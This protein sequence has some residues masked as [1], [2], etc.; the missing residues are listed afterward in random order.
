MTQFFR[1]GDCIISLH[2]C[3]KYKKTDNTTIIGERNE[4]HA[5]RDSL[6]LLSFSS[7]HCWPTST[8]AL[9]PCFHSFTL[10]F[11]YFWN[12]QSSFFTLSMSALQGDELKIS[13]SSYSKGEKNIIMM[14]WGTIAVGNEEDF[15]MKDATTN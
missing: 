12:P 8:S 2:G 13:T 10:L 3:D 1:Y 11:S 5:Q 4:R 15:L 6:T 7:C 14:A 9:S